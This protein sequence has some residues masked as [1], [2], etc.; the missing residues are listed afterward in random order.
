AFGLDWIPIPI[1]IPRIFS[2]PREQTVT[3]TQPQL[4]VANAN[5][6]A[7][8]PVVY[9]APPPV[10]YGAP[11]PVYQVPAPVVMPSYGAPPPQQPPCSYG[12]APPCGSDKGYGQGP[13]GKDTNDKQAAIMKESLNSVEKKLELVEKMLK[14]RGHET[15]S[16]QD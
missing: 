6:G 7:P 9:G 11:P 14:D 15:P 10:V 12:Q 13:P 4:P 8:P 2:L 3:V 5:F 16:K 1:P